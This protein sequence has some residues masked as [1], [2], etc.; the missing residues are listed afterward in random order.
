ME[1]FPVSLSIFDL[2]ALL[3][4]SR[5]LVESHDPDFIINNLL[6][7]AMGKVMSARA[8][9]LL[10]E[11]ID[12]Q[13]RVVKSKGK[14]SWKDGQAF[15][16][17]EELTRLSGDNASSSLLAAEVVPKSLYD[18]GI[19]VM[20]NLR[21]SERHLGYLCMGGK[22]NGI[23]LNDAEKGFL[24]SLVYM[25]ATA[26]GNSFLV[27][28][29]KK[30]NRDL[31]LKVQEMHTLFDLSKEF[32][33]A[34]EQDQILR[35]F[36]FALLG[37]MLVRSFFMV[38]YD[39]ELI[40]SSGMKKV[41]NPDELKDLFASG[42][43]ITEVDDD[44]KRKVPCLHENKIEVLI[45]LNYNEGQPVCLG[46]GK[47]GGGQSYKEYD[48]SFLISLGNLVLLS[49]QK[50]YLLE[51]Q[52]EKKRIEEELN[53]ARAIQQKLLPESL[54]ATEGFDLAATNISSRQVGGDYYDVIPYNGSLF[55][56]IADVT[57]KGAPAA[58]LMAN[59]QAMLHV[60]IPFDIDLAEA[61]AKINSNIFKNTASD[62]FI[63]FFWGK[64]DMSTKVFTYVN[65]GHNPPILFRRKNQTCEELT[66]GGILLGAMQTVQPYYEGNIKLEQDDIL[67]FFTDGV[68]EAMNSYNEVYSE[69]RLIESVWTNS[70]LDATQLLKNIIQDV[71]A[72][73]DHQ[74]GD[75]L[76]LM[77]VKNT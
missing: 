46:L 11:P 77:V 61:T 48:F 35:I 31:D 67:V 3:D 29:I 16:A 22:V 30:A 68:T 10:Y 5:L 74:L 17:T 41:P 27:S 23:H 7:I 12:D 53:L 42:E 40:T 4:T 62:M 18:A 1:R 36:K 9:V 65:A 56:A 21:T 51:E 32:N 19:T 14:L 2:K 38:A 33:G 52:L 45:Y 6:L 37:Q 59:L 15:K 60:M 39:N 54:P 43:T 75:D 13:Y 63:S 76:T 28:E 49:L 71:E 26:L 55:F 57:G 25:S 66:T 20:I 72:F 8:M 47:R 34:I 69:A 58:L 50:A 64:I 73:C 70:H 24:E 44:L